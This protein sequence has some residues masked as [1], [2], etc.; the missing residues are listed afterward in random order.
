MVSWNVLTEEYRN[1]RVAAD[2]LVE[3]LKHAEA[4][5]RVT[6]GT[7]GALVPGHFCHHRH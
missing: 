3:R 4:G 6:W 1:R 7:G 2:I 5:R